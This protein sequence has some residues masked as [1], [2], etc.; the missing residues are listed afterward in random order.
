MANRYLADVS[1]AFGPTH[2][3]P[4]RVGDPHNTEKRI[5][6]FIFEGPEGS[7]VAKLRKAHEEVIGA[8]QDLRNWKE[9]VVASSKYTPLGIQE[10]VGA[11]AMEE[12]LPRVRR[13]RAVVEKV[14]K[15]ITERRD[16]L[17]LAAPT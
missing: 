2:I 13:A 12:A 11:R 16:S 4:P 7:A 1:K 10:S 14:M 17:K 8:V 3:G 6:K 5:S 15:E 9:R